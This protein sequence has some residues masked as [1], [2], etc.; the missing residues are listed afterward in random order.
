MQRRSFLEQSLRA[1]SGGIAAGLVAGVT[2]GLGGPA[3]ARRVF[4]EDGELDYLGLRQGDLGQVVG[5]RRVR[6]S[7]ASGDFV[8]R[9]DTNLQLGA[10]ATPRY[11][12]EQHSEEVWRDGWLQA[13]VCDTDDDGALWRV[14]AE[15]QG[16]IFRGAVNDFSFTVSGYPITSTLWH[17]DV[18][19]Q[20]A[21]LDVADARVKLISG[22]LLG[23]E[24]VSAAGAKV[25]AKRYA[26][27]GEINHD[28]WYDRDCSLV[29]FSLPLRDGSL[30]VFEAQ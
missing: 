21:L 11:R 5:R 8:A 27:R 4:P 24:T 7:R 12:F 26:I 3:Q 15:R 13:I 20:Q 9:I 14:R 22:R 1:C 17:R 30:L 23:E 18:P 2:V 10:A 28:L 25:S 19:S 6:F 29:R 16:G